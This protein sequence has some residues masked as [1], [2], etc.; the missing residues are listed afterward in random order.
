M[1]FDNESGTYED[2]K[3]G[4]RIPSR[5]AHNTSGEFLSTMY[6]RYASARPAPVYKHWTV[7]SNNHNG[8]AKYYYTRI[9]AYHSTD[10]PSEPLKSCPPTT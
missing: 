7:H 3:W 2:H 1:S 4:G 5:A 8:R 9:P 6:C 10:T